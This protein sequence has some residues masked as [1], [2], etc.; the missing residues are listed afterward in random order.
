LGGAPGEEKMMKNINQALNAYETKYRRSGLP[1]LTVS[2]LYDLFPSQPSQ[3]SAKWSWSRSN[4]WPHANRAGVYFIFGDTGN[5]LY[6]GKASRGSIGARLDEYFG[7]EKLTKGCRIIEPQ[8]WRERPRY[9]AALA[10]PEDM[11][12]EAAALEEFLIRELQPP[13]NAAGLEA[14]ADRSLTSKGED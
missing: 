5:L 10:V 6:V 12:F 7:Y 14:I 3:I 8:A 13:L 9:V 4:P 2:G 1:A 11:W